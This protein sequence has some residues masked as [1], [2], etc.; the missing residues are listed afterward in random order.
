MRVDPCWSWPRCHWS[1]PPRLSWG[2][3]AHRSAGAELP[4]ACGRGPCREVRA[5]R[6][7]RCG[8]A[9]VRIAGC[10]AGAA[11]ALAN[12]YASRSVRSRGFGIRVGQGVRSPWAF[13]RRLC[14]CLSLRQ[15]Q[16]SVR[17]HNRGGLLI[18]RFKQG[19]NQGHNGRWRFMRERAVNIEK[20]KSFTE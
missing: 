4:Q 17:N 3:S 19:E 13:A 10:E 5:R 1:A 6:R 14:R 9:A 11:Q 8:C 2:S 7:C 15:R 16:I 18:E 12:P 20:N